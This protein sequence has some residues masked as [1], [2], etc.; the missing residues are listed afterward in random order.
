M[1]HVLFKGTPVVLHFGKQQKLNCKT[2]CRG[3]TGGMSWTILISL[4]TLV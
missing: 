3:F 2:T 4:Y 1:C